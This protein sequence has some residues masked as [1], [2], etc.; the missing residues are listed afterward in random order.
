[1]HLL[2]QIK[3]INTFEGQRH[4]DHNM[5]FGMQTSPRIWCTFFTLVMWITIHVYACADLMHYMD[6]VWSYET[7]PILVFYEPLNDWYPCKQ[8]KLLQLDDLGLPHDKKKQVFAHTL[9]IIGF[10]C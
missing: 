10:F 9:E 7:D 5:T 2:W 8:V 4:V 1:M 3:Q 6:D